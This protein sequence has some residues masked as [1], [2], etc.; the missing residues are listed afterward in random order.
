MAD[1]AEPSSEASYGASAPTIVASLGGWGDTMLAVL[2][3]VVPEAETVVALDDAPPAG[4]EIV[5]T[6]GRSRKE[7]GRL[8]TP[9]TR[10]VH[11]LSTG[12]DGIELEAFGDRTITCSRG[13]SAEAISEFVLATMLAFVKH[14]PELWI[15]EPPE[16]WNT[17]TLEPLAGK[18]V[19]LVGVGAI[20]AEVARRARAFD[21]RVLGYRRRDVPTPH[22]DIEL[23]R[24]LPEL[25]GESDHVVIAAPATEETYHL[26]DAEA[27]AAIKP[28]AHLV[29][30]A[31]GTLIDQDALIAALDDGRIARATLDVVDPEP[32]PAGHPLYSHPL[33]R[34][35]PHVSWATPTTMR[36]TIEIFGENVHRYRAG[37]DLVGVVD[38]QAGY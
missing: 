24:S 22:P 4:A 38:P 23:V 7:L 16:R 27:L 15:D 25:L 13:A 26:L 21:M 11:L 10:W 36:R 33:V 18:T 28:G 2:R 20:G 31:R 32:L 3:G 12:V 17:A 5:V 14:L 34:L 8:V 35:S 19:G 29:N 1:P 30:I 6:F 37:E 9:A